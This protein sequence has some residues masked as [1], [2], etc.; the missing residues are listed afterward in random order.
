MIL[1]LLMLIAAQDAPIDCDKQETQL[2]MNEC[3]GRAYLEA[4]QAMNKQWKVTLAAMRERDKGPDDGFG[5]PSAQLLLEAQ[6]AW[7]AYRDAHCRV[8]GQY[9]RG[10]SMQP[11]LVSMCKTQLT[12]AR[13]EDLRQLIEDQ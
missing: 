13:T 7:L 2:D 4:D 12:A 6:R 8:E 10:G 5:P 3:A 1:P 9:A 11:M